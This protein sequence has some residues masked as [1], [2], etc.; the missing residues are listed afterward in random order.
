MHDLRMAGLVSVFGLFLGSSAGAL[1]LAPGDTLS[2]SDYNDF[3]EVANG[4]PNW[5]GT[6]LG[7]F[8]RSATETRDGFD[9]FEVVEDL[10]IV[11]GVIDTAVSRSDIGGNLTF[12]YGFSSIDDSG[13]GS[14]NGVAG[15]MVTG[16]AD[17]DVEI[18][19]NYDAMPFVPLISRSGDGDKITV[20]YGFPED[21][22][23]AFG[24]PYE[25]IL[26]RVSAPD[27][28]LTGT[29]F[30]DINIDTFGVTQRMLDRMPVP[31]AIPLPLP[32]V[33]LVGGIGLLAVHRL[34][35]K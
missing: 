3:G 26:V 28:R 14:T 5:F 10:Y 13:A 32:G 17:Y 1:S 34:R 7:M 16:F 20:D 27:F 23:Q 8:S 25:T 12:G 2:Q 18:G 9:G 6:S 21:T 19:W 22:L 35:R 4:D 31:A 30:V 11:T 33:L 29:G 24:A 15:F